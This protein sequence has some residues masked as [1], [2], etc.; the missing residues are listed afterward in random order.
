M[1]E[2][3]MRR[4]RFGLTKVDAQIG[5]GRGMEEGRLYVVA[6]RPGMGKSGVG[7]SALLTT[8]NAGGNAIMFSLEMPRREVMDRMCASVAEVD[9]RRIQAKQLS[10]EEAQRVIPSLE[11]IAR[12]PWFIDDTGSLPISEIR[13]RALTQHAKTPLS[14]VVIDHAHIVGYEPGTDD[15]EERH[16]SNVSHTC[17]ALSK[18]LACPVLLLMQLNRKCEER[19][20]KR[21]QLS[22][23]RGSGALEQDAD[24]VLFVYRD[25]VY[26]RASPDVG[27][28]ELICAK[29]RNGPLFT[30]RVAYNAGLTRFK[31]AVETAPR[32][33]VTVVPVDTRYERDGDDF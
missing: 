27:H 10:A 4:A 13:A 5:D 23:L 16:L 6:G 25:E 29:Q 22:D 21:P 2:G 19:P 24:M 12:L 8:A 31:D 15:K 26:D 9:A 30:A 28:A 33:A 32:Q 14:L 7:I 17:K 20:N 3:G 11:V 18:E 1:T